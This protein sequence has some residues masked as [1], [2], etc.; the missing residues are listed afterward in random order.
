MKCGGPE[1]GSGE[2]IRVETA[3]STSIRIEFS[4]MIRF[5][6][7]NLITFGSGHR[8]MLP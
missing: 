8:H 1:E 3:R 7:W 6:K 4:L 5:Y 2:S